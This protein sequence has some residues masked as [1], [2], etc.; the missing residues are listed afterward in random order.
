MSPVP[1][2]R[3]MREVE[4][5]RTSLVAD[6]ELRRRHG[7]ALT[8]RTQREQEAVLRREGELAEGHAA[9]RF[10]GF[11]TVSASGP[12]QLEA[13]CRRLEQAGALARLE[14]RRLYGAQSEAFC[15]TLPLARGCS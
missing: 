11:V 8:A 12:S 13:A 5:D 4:R 1:P 3:A 6:G 7:F 14:L 9:Y 15:C 2:V 10:S